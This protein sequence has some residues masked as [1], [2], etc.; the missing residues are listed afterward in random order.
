MPENSIGLSN[1]S[2]CYLALNR[3]DEAKGA[4]QEAQSR[5]V[6]NS[7]LHLNRYYLAVLQS[8]AS[9]MQEQIAWA[10]GK[11]TAEDWML[12]VHLYTE[13]EH[14]RLAK[15]HEF[16]QRAVESARRNDAKET[17]ALWQVNGALR[18]AEFGNATKAREAAADALALSATK[19]IEVLAALALARAGDW[20]GAEKLAD[21][22]S[23]A[24]SLDSLIQGYWLPAVRASLELNHGNEQR[25]I[26]FLQ[27]TSAYELG[28]T[29]PFNS[30]GTLYPAYL[31]GEAYLKAGQAQQAAA[32]FQKF[33]DYRGVV[34]NYPL[35][36]LAHLQLGRAYTL[37]SDVT[38]AR[39]AYQDFLAL[40]KDATPTS[41]S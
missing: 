13:A 29:P 31:R 9:A 12:S 36:A 22:V 38:K 24:V 19:E 34:L 5:K 3:L 10:M 17:A 23:H 32:E 28:E 26:Q 35:S 15:A 25:A 20:A 33:L 6:D 21:K 16:T 40:W 39:T 8:D 27:P 4:L 7:F 37:G 1:L 2:T 11:P 14:G 18:Q 41:P 30:I